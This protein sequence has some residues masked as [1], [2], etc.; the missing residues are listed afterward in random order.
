MTFSPVSK[1][2]SALCGLTLIGALLSSGSALAQSNQV[3][4]ISPDGSVD[5]VGEFVEFS[6]DTY[7]VRTLLGDLR[8]SSSRVRCEGDACPAVETDVAAETLAVETESDAE[9]R[10]ATVD[11]PQDEIERPADSVV[12]ET[13]T[14]SES[15]PAPE[16]APAPTVETIVQAAVQT[17]AAPV[18][19]APVDPAPEIVAN[20]VHVT[21]SAVMGTGIVPLLMEGYAGA[22]DAQIDTVT[23]PDG[24]WTTAVL[25]GDG[26]FGDDLGAYMINNTDSDGAFRALLEK[27]ARI[28]M[29]ARRITPDEARALRDAGATGMTNPEN[30]R[31]VA[32][33][34]IV[35]V[36]N[37]DNDVESLTMEQVAQIYAGKIDNWS[38]VG[39][40]DLPIMI[41]G[42]AADT[43]SSAIFYDTITA[44]TD[45][46]ERADDIVIADSMPEVSTLVSEKP[47]AIG[48]VSYASKRGA[49]PINLVNACGLTMVPDAFSAR[50]EEYAMQRRLYLY[51]R[52]DDTSGAAEDFLD[53]AASADADAVIRKAGFIDM[54]IDAR[55]Q[56]LN[57]NRARLLLDPTADDYEGGVM[58]EMLGR[59]I[60]YERLS[61]TF[62]FRTG[63]ARLD[64]RGAMDMSRLIDHL[65]RQPAGSR[66]AF[67]GFTDDVGTFDNNRD[68]SISR[69]E[70]VMQDVM[71]IGGDTLADLDIIAEGFGEIAPAACNTDDDGRRINRR[72]E[73]WIQPGG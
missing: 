25:I 6:N 21:G 62:R 64:E 46:L 16:P 60:D 59:M 4:L 14:A 67:V 70:Q 13:E 2:G 51:K 57:S 66:V 19:Q 72:V 31:I 20:G 65:A 63:S 8:L 3:N 44:Q 69:A 45:R 26:G 56:S 61:T 32:V 23:A 1:G 30:E 39:G 37:P 47:G 17:E 55:S 15:A 42:R 49:K 27:S 29:S 9:I 35:V 24:G 33:D 7:V 48:Y 38:Q 71:E 73:V 40:S 10:A 52:G 12:V 11:A 28:G 68:L 50:T 54:G 22:L 18:V 5:I 53:Y 36:V 43:D 41:V 34:S 58:R